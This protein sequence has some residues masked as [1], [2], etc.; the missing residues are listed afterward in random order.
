MQKNP[1]AEINKIAKLNQETM[2]IENCA[3]EN[4]LKN[5]HGNVVC[6]KMKMMKDVE[7]K[8]GYLNIFPNY[9]H[10]NRKDGLGMPSLSPKAIGP[11]VHNQP[12][13]PIAKNLENFH[14]GN[15]VF[16]DEV[17]E[18]GNPTNAF[19]T[20][21]KNM[22]NDEIPHRHKKNAT[23]IN[24]QNKNI[25]LYSIWILQNG[26]KQRVLYFESRQFYS[27][28]YERHVKN[29][30]NYLLLCDKIK[31][32]YNLQICGYDAYIV[33][34]TVEDHYLDIS[35][36]FGHEL[37][38]YTMLTHKESDYPWRKYKTYNF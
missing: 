10:L 2:E 13:L 29:D 38:L 21:Q 15:K 19:F 11:I 12:N 33:E 3:R 22:Y 36:P 4:R 34:K 35:R 31:N 16:S 6:Y 30:A 1:N 23:K 9:K 26:T 37:V 17:D 5:K 8:K 24:G 28:Y 27:N 14:Q 32:G 7:Y 18:N 25:P 20:T